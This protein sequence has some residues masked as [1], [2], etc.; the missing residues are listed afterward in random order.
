M[1]NTK[2][3]IA[4]VLE[5]MI[6]ISL[7]VCSACGLLDSYWSGMGTALIF[8]SA[9]F[10]I[11]QIRYSKDK[12]YQEYVDVEAKD[13]RNKYLRMKAWSWAGYWFLMISAVASIVLKLIGLDEYS[14][15]AGG[16]VCVLVLL[17]WL[18]YLILRKK[19]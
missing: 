14:V 4:L 10:M 15:V 19:Y 5:I 1:K 2:R 11:Q 6:G 13:E 17:Y 9:V 16:S 8:V 12:A 3:L 7:I 18:S